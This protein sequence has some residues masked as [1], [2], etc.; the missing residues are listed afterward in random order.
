M[1]YNVERIQQAV[2]AQ[3]GLSW[4]GKETGEHRALK[5]YRVLK[6]KR[7][8]LLLDDVWEEIDLEK[9]SVPR[10]DREKNVK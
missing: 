10:P 1:G 4:D 8:L 5:I 3:L 9:A 6:Q 2:G 7:F